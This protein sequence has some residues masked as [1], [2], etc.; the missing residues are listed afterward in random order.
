[1]SQSKMDEL[2]IYR[3]DN[4]VVMSKAEHTFFACVGLADTESSKEDINIVR[5]HDDVVKSLGIQFD[6]IVTV[7]LSLCLIH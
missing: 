5:I 6:D 7:S 2:S 1:M 4:V 3:G